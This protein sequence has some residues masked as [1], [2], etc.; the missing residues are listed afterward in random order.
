MAY[1]DGYDWIG[2]PHEQD[3]PPRC[4]ECDVCMVDVGLWRP[5]WECHNSQCE[6]CD[7]F[8]KDLEDQ[9]RLHE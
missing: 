8:Y 3:E 5:R 2:N 4:P 1:P 9:W 6:N 7:P